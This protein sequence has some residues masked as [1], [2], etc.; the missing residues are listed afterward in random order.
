MHDLTVLDA[1][2]LFQTERGVR[3]ERRSCGEPPE[4][5]AQRKVAAITPGVRE[6]TTSRACREGHTLISAAHG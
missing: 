5:F 4:P 2:H 3:D 6:L 1:Q